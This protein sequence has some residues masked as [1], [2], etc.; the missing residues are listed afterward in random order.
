M[1]DVFEGPGWWMASDGKWYPPERHPDN[2]YRTQFAATPSSTQPSAPV[3]EPSPAQATAPHVGST[4][5]SAALQVDAAQS[6]SAQMHGAASPSPAVSS[7]PVPETGPPGGNDTQSVP[8]RRQNNGLSETMPPSVADTDDIASPPASAEDGWVTHE[9][10]ATPQIERDAVRVSKA[11]PI[12]ADDLRPAAPT[13]IPPSVSSITSDN[14]DIEIELQRRGDPTSA[15]LLGAQ[16]VK[17]ATPTKTTDLVV[18]RPLHEDVDVPLRSRLTSVLIFL[19]GIA[20]IVGSFLTWV[21]GEVEQSG[22]DRGDGLATIIAGVVGAAAAGPIFVGFRHAL[23]RAATIIAGLTGL[24]V[25]GIVVITTLDSSG[26]TTR[27]VG[28]GV[29]VIAAAAA[30]MVLAGISDPGDTDW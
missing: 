7:V 22:W 9:Q 24:V 15:V 17:A 20:L 29:I 8:N 6:S 12:A 14:P 1:S 10:P 27:S 30:A 26:E 23:P 19:S 4:Q 13:R 25:A 5:P 16:A 18:V 28:V 11:E 3:A 21:T 2:A